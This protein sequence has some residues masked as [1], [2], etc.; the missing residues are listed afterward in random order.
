[1]ARNVRG[2]AMG[3][4]RS[5][6]SLGT[7]G[8]ENRTSGGVRGVGQTPPP[9]RSPS[10]S[11]EL[12]NW[13]MALWPG[14]LLLSITTGQFYSKAK[15]CPVGHRTHKNRYQPKALQRV[16]HLSR[17]GLNNRLQPPVCT[18][19]FRD[20]CALAFAL[21][22]SPPLPPPF[23]QDACLVSSRITPTHPNLN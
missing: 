9:T 14:L 8:C 17:Y 12:A 20:T 23:G 1:M 7:A 10:W 22:E 5:R 6:K 2:K 18:Q 21:R 13:L 19:F 11:P 4:L 15:N 3:R 16:G